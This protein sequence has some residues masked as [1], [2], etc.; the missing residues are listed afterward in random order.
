[1]FH[2]KKTIDVED[3]LMLPTIVIIYLFIGIEKMNVG[4]WHAH[5]LFGSS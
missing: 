4:K 5:S 1:M 3:K 2:Q